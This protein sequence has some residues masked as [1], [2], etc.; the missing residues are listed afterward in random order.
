[1]D[2]HTLVDPLALVRSPKKLLIGGRWVAAQSG[3]TLPSENPVTEQEITQIARAGAADVD[4]AVTAAQ[5]AFEGPAWGGMNP[6]DRTRLLFKVASAIDAHSEEL[7]LLETLDNGMPL[8]AARFMVQATARQFEYFAGW[9]TKMTGAVQP[10]DQAFFNYTTREPLGVCGQIIPWNAPLLMA[11]WKLAPALACGNTV[12]LKPAEQTSLSVLRLGELML[13]VGLPDG[14]VNIVTG[15]GPE[16]G[17][18]IVNHPRIAKIAF[19]GSTRVGKDILRKSADNLK[20]V[21]LELG[22]KSPNVIFSDADIHMALT[23]ATMGYCSLS[24]QVCVAGTRIF[25]QESICDELS[26]RLVAMAQEQKLGDPM[27]PE[28]T[29][30]PLISRQQL[31]R[32]SDYVSVG[33]DE[34][35]RLLTGGQRSGNKGYF[36][37]PTIF[38]N[39]RPDMRIVREEIFG[40]VAVIIPFKDENDAVLQGNTTDYGLGAAV[41]TRDVGRAHRVARSLKAGT[42]WVNTYA[43]GDPTMPFGGYKQSG[44]GRENGA[45][46]IEA[47]TQTK[48]VFVRM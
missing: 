4:L 15:I 43:D 9:P 6:H 19:T 22:G 10:S 36:H 24:G 26:A 37:Q 32:V 8:M 12:V 31:K 1:M 18:A 3:Q 27:K 42:V 45:E 17:E 16:A 48:A 14:V 38:T 21:T 47:Y 2:T 29:M 20:K 5:K 23:F 40:P 34:G 11:G 28:T 25:A 46:V 41:W 7:A 13:E 33:R 30:G 39:V 44:I 35:A